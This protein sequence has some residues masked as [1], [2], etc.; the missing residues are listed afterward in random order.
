VEPVKLGG[1]LT[2]GL[3]FGNRTAGTL[4]AGVVLRLPVPEGTEFVSASDGGVQNADGIVEWTVGTLN[5]GQTG[6]QDL[7]VQADAALHGGAVLRAAAQIEDNTGRRTRATA[8]TRV[9][10]VVPLSLTID[11][12]PDP[13]APGAVLSGSLA[14]ENLGAVQLLGVTVEVFLPDE[15]VAF[16]T[17]VTS[18][19]TAMC[20]GDQFPT[21]CSVRERLVWTVGTLAPTA[22]VT[23][24]MPPHLQA[25]VVPGK[26]IPFNALAIENGG[27][28]AAARASLR[29]KTP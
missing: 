24:T 6:H 2:Y 26:V 29:V 14:V 10:A 5:P 1:M 20:I 25:N 7:V 8:E 18:G 21:T 28:T 19:A 27:F 23:L 16:G 11:V 12:T 22:L 17:N 13:A 4:A 3:S 9:E 15:I